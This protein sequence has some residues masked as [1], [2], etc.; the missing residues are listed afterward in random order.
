MQQLLR[1]NTNL[2]ICNSE[3]SAQ[4]LLMWQQDVQAA[5]TV[6]DSLKTVHISRQNLFW[7]L[8]KLRK[9]IRQSSGV[10]LECVTEHYTYI[11]CPHFDSL[12]RTCTTSL[13]S[14]RKFPKAPASLLSSVA[15]KRINGGKVTS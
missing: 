8:S 11:S 12:L 5:T 1:C 7:S 14:F 6:A 15:V 2:L 3:I 13:L 4:A 9:W 10:K